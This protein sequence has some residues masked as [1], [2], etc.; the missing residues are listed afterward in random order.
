MHIADSRGLNGFF[1]PIKHIGYDKPPAGGEPWSLDLRCAHFGVRVRDRL[2]NVANKNVGKWVT[3]DVGDFTG[4]FIWNRDTREISTIREVYPT[5]VVA[6]VVEGAVVRFGRGGAV[7]ARVIRKPWEADDRLAM[8]RTDQPAYLPQ[9]PGGWLGVTVEAQEETAQHELFMSTDPRACAPDSGGV[10]ANGSIVCDV[11]ATGDADTARAARLQTHERVAHSEG[12]YTLAWQGTA[13]RKGGGGYGAWYGRGD[14]GAPGGAAGAHVVNLASWERGGPLCSG[15]STAD[16][17]RR[18]VNADGEAEQPLHIHWRALVYRNKEQDGPIRI[19]EWRKGVESG[20]P[21]RVWMGWNPDRLEWDYYTRQPFIPTPWDEVP[22]PKEQV[23]PPPDDGEPNW[24]GF[25]WWWW[26]G[27]GGGNPGGG[28]GGG[29]PDGGDGEVGEPVGEPSD[30]AAGAPPGGARGSPSQGEPI[31]DQPGF[32][33]PRKRKRKPKVGPKGDAPDKPEGAGEATDGGGARGPMAP[34]R[35]ERELSVPSLY[36]T[37]ARDRDSQGGDGRYGG[38]GGDTG[39]DPPDGSAS[40]APPGGAPTP[41]PAPDL[42]RVDPRTSDPDDPRGEAGYDPYKPEYKVHA[43]PTPDIRGFVGRLTPYARER[44]G[45]VP[46]L[47]HFSGLP[48]VTGG[49]WEYQSEP[50]VR[51][52]SGTAL[53]GAVVFGHA[54]YRPDGPDDQSDVIGEI[55]LLL[56]N[57]Y[58]GGSAVRRF[59][60]GEYDREADTVAGFAGF[61]PAGTEAARNLELRYLDASGAARTGTLTSYGHIR[62]G[63]DSTYSLGTATARSAVVHTD[64]LGAASAPAD[65][66][67]VTD[68]TVYGT[69]TATLPAHA[70]R[71]QSGGADP[72]KLDDLAAPDDNTDLD[73]SAAKHGLLPKLPGSS[74]L[75]LDGTGNWGTPPGTGGSGDMLAANNLSDV[76]SAVEAADNLSTK[77]ADIAAATT[78]DIG[79]STGTYVEVTGS[80]VTITGLGTCTA[81]I[82]RVVRFTGANTLTYNGTSLILPGGVDITTV[83]GDVGI[84]RSLG[85]GNWL[86]VN[87]SPIIPQAT[88]TEQEAGA[89]VA[90]FVSPGRQHYHQSAAKAWVQF[91]GTGTPAANASYNLSSITDNG[92]GDYTLNWTNA[93][94]SGN[95]VVVGSGKWDTT[96]VNDHAPAVGVNR[97]TSNPATGSCRIG[98]SNTTDGSSQDVVQVHIAVFGD[99]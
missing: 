73:A 44:G 19:T 8:L 39:F 35:L 60:W 34:I 97:V 7:G 80:S 37:G 49:R 64:A 22:I 94:S 67:H 96:A 76:A 82:E 52:G 48:Q 24:G 21:T 29:D 99:L 56:Y 93:F 45:P 2:Q 1:L 61:M 86:C 36:I 69:L 51:F 59:G 27:G 31:N 85:S 70:S 17:H 65:E 79:R 83:A 57:G 16:R 75:Y 6:G 9:P 84:F 30:G 25:W 46:L 38:P 95:Y 26:W 43:D 89:S 5:V 40:P 28:P 47:A 72:I 77:G 42:G 18:L 23:P 4:A 54:G 62:W 63:A 32:D 91:N 10:A 15:H 98:V 74:S 55:D 41:A 14:S 87:Y 58:R 71:H 92:T 68:L 12:R 11:T 53:A 3:D 81:G 78:T 20:V 13:A 88:Q 50:G 90:R 33:F 66:A